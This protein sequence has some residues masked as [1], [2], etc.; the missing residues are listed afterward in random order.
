MGDAA[1]FIYPG[2]IQARASGPAK[3]L[4]LASGRTT[5]KEAL[6]VVRSS[7]GY[8]FEA[9]VSAADFPAPFWHALRGAGVAT[10]VFEMP[11]PA[12]DAA[13]E[14][15]AKADA[16]TTKMTVRPL[17]AEVGA[18][19]SFL[20]G[21][22]TY[23]YHEERAAT[24]ARAL[25]TEH[26]TGTRFSLFLGDNVYCDVHPTHVGPDPAA[27][28]ARIYA[29]AFA[30]SDGLRRAMSAGPTMFAF[31]D[32]D[33]YDGYPATQPH[34]ARTWVP[35]V[36]DA[37]VRAAAQA[38]DMIP[39][40][41]NPDSVVSG[42]KSYRFDV[43]PVSFFVLDARTHRTKLDAAW[44]GLTT[45]D[46]LEQLEAWA[47]SLVAPGVLA[48]EQPLYIE[49]GTFHEP[50][51]P[52]FSRQFERILRAIAAAPFDILVL[53]GDLHWSQLVRL[54]LGGRPIYE[55][56][57]SPFIRIPSFA[58]NMLARAI[59]TPEDQESQN[60]V[61]PKAITRPAIAVP[62]DVV[63]YVMGSS[64]ANTF[65]RVRLTTP[66]VGR[67][68]VDVDFFDHAAGRVALSE[69]DRGR[70]LQPSVA[71]GSP[72]LTRLSLGARP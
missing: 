49:D 36:R 19:L 46:E 11:S 64:V 51:P 71:I 35:F 45:D 52:A 38:I 16:L 14:I 17:P 15:V 41:M 30:E 62:L 34:V 33:F 27:H 48:L 65:A 70:G 31:D 53:A 61:I 68:D 26:S 22:C 20:F 10:Y 59:G 4:V 18:G 23:G 28:V 47:A 39:S 9:R 57:S 72:C 69:P 40:S 44:P 42:G 1:L 13:L 8:A 12:D 43:A 6:L 60:V 29:H 3:V 66:A 24:L 21:S 5:P 58:R 63:E 25:E 7:S 54:E 2:F 50:S 56:T 32:H 37:H 67:L 55:V